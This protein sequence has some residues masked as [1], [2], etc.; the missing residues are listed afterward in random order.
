MFQT[1]CRWKYSQLHVD[2]GRQSI[3]P[4]DPS[5][6]NQQNLSDRWLDATP[7]GA[8]LIRD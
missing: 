5:P 7:R 3:P 6:Q 8:D 1:T 2:G 4:A